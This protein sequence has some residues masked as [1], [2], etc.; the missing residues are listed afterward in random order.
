M[1]VSQFSLDKSTMLS[2][3]MTIEA[4]LSKALKKME[5]IQIWI[6]MAAMTTSRKHAFL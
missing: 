3:N 4:I 2:A 1:T 6:H 5:I